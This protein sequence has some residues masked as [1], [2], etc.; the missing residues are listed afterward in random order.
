MSFGT[1]A[2]NLFL[3]ATENTVTD[4]FNRKLVPI[5][6]DNPMPVSAHTGDNLPPVLTDVSFD[7]NL[8]L[9]TL[10]FD[11][12]VNDTS[13]DVTRVRLVGAMASR[14]DLTGGIATATSLPVIQ[15]TLSNQ[16]L[17]N[18]KA[19]FNLAVSPTTISVQPRAN[20]VSDTS[21]NVIQEL[22]MTVPASVFIDDFNRPS[23][24]SFTLD[25]DADILI[26]TFN[27]TVDTNTLLVADLYLQHLRNSTVSISLSGSTVTSSP[28]S[29]VQISIGYS[30][31]TEIKRN[32]MLAV[33]RR[34]TW[35]SFDEIALNDTAANPV[36]PIDFM[37]AM[38]VDNF[39]DD[40]TAPLLTSYALDLNA[41]TL[42]LTFSET[43]DAFSVNF[44]TITLRSSPSDSAS[45]YTL[46]GGSVVPFMDDPVITIQFTFDDINAIKS[47]RSLATT[48]ATT[49]LSLGND[50]LF[51]MAGN[52]LN[53]VESQPITPSDYA[54]DATQPTL[55]SFDL[56]MRNGTEPLEIVLRFSESVDINSLFANL[57]TLHLTNQS[58]STTDYTLTGGTRSLPD[59]PNVTVFV[60]SADLTAIRARAPLAQF[61]ETSYLSVATGAVRDLASLSI[62]QQGLIPVSQYLADLI[63]PVV[64]DFSLDMN[65]GRL[66]LT[67]SEVIQFLTLDVTAIRLQATSSGPP[68]VTLSAS[69]QL[70]TTTNSSVM[71]IQISTSD[72]DQIKQFPNLAVG[73]NSTYIALSPTVRDIANN[74]VEE[75]FMTSAMR[76]SDYIPDST[77]P[78]LL[79]F[80][81]NVIDGTLTLTFDETVN[82]SSITPQNIQFAD[83]DDILTYTLTGGVSS[84]LYNSVVVFTLTE[85][86][87]NGLKAVDGVA[88]SLNNTYLNLFAG[89]ILDMNG[90]ANSPSLNRRASGFTK[91]T[92]DPVLETFDIDMDEGLL[93]LSFDETVNVSSLQ[94][95][96]IRLHGRSTVTYNLNTSSVNH[97]PLPTVTVQL[98][99]LDLN[100]LKRLRICLENDTCLLSFPST[101]VSDMVGRSVVAIATSTPQSVTNHTRDTTNPQLVDFTEI[102]LITREITLQFSETIDVT[103]FNSTQVTLQSFFVDDPPSVSYQ[104]NEVET[105]L[106]GDD[107]TLQFV[108]TQSDLFAIKDTED[109]C[110]RRSN[111]YVTITSATVQDM[112]GNMNDPILQEFPGKVV[113]T[114]RDDTVNPTLLRFDFDVNSGS[115]TLTFSE[116]MEAQSIDASGIT[117]LSMPF[118]PIFDQFTLTGGRTLNTSGDVVVVLQLSATDLN[119]LKASTFVKSDANTYLAISA[120]TITDVSFSRNRVSAMNISNPLRVSMYTRD[121]TPPE[122]LS[123]QLDLNSDQLI[124]TFNEPVSTNS[125]NFTALTLQNDSSTPIFSRT[126]VG[127][128]VLTTELASLV[129][130]TQLHPADISVLKLTDGFG[131]NTNNTYISAAQ[132]AFTDTANNPIEAITSMM[133][134]FHVSDT[135]RAR[136]MSFS[137]DMQTGQLDLTFSDIIVASMLDASAIGIQD[138]RFAND[139]SSVRLST[140]STT[141]SSDGYDITVSIHPLDLLRVKSVSGL[142]T[143]INTTWITMQ[144]FAI[145]DA[146]GQDVLAITNGKALRVTGFTADTTNPSVDGF[147]LDLNTG[148]LNITFSDTVDHLLL[149]V[150]LISIVSDRVPTI[151]L[152]LAGGQVDRSVNGRTVSVTLVVS[153]LNELK[154]NTAIGSTTSNTFLTIGPNVISDLAGNYLA[155]IPISAALQA[156]EIIPD[157]TGPELRSFELDLNAGRLIVTFSEPVDASSVNTLGYTLQS[158]RD[159]TFFRSEQYT[160]QTGVS[161]GVNGLVI[162][163]AFSEN[164]LNGIFAI[165]ALGNTVLDTYLIISNISVQDIG[166]N[167][168]IP[169][170]LTDGIQASSVSADTNA[171]RLISYVVDMNTGLLSLSFTEVVLTGSVRF[172]QI[173]LQNSP[174]ASESSTYT[175]TLTGGTT[176]SVEAETLNITFSEADLSV[177]QANLALATESSNTYLSFTSLTLTDAQNFPVIPV[178]RET[179]R[180]VTTFI[181]DTTP[182][183][184]LSFDFDLNS[185]NLSLTFDE[186][187]NTSRVTF[188]RIILRSSSNANATL[189]PL[190]GSTGDNGLASTV[191]INIGAGNLNNIKAN[192]TLATSAQTTHLSLQS[193]V[194]ED[195]NGNSY[196]DAATVRGVTRFTSD[197]TD[198]QLVNFDLNIDSGELILTFSETVNVEG[199]LDVR[200][201]TVQSEE[202]TADISVRLR[203]SISLSTNSP[204]I[205]I[206]LSPSDLNNLKSQPLLATNANNTYLSIL[207]LAIR[208]MANRPLQSI[209]STNAQP[210]QTFTEDRTGPEIDRFELDMNTGILALTFNEYVNESSLDLQY[211]TLRSSRDV[212]AETVTLTNSATIISFRGTAVMLQLSVQDVNAIKSQRSLATSID[213]TFLEAMANTIL[214]MN[215]NTLMSIPSNLAEP[216]E[217]YI[218]DT[219]RPSMISFEMDINTETLTIRFSETIDSLTADPTNITLQQDAQQLANFLTLSGGT[220]TSGDSPNITIR[221]SSVDLNELSRLGIC[222]A[223]D[224]CFIAFP[225]NTFDDMFGNPVIAIDESG[226]IS[227]R[228]FIVDRTPPMFVRFTSF[229]LDSGLLTLEFSETVRVSTVNFSALSFDA[230][231]HSSTPRYTLMHGGRVL[232][233]DREI[234]TI[235]LSTSDLNGIK[236]TQDVCDDEN[237]CW[238]RFTRDFIRDITDNQITEVASRADLG[239]ADLPGVFTPDTTRPLLTSFDL[240]LDNGELTLNFDE[241]IRF[242]DFS[243]TELTLANSSDALAFYQLTGGSRITSMDGTE[244]RFRLINSDLG[245]VKAAIDLATSQNNTYLNFTSD[246]VTDVSVMR[247]PVNTT[248]LS[249]GLLQVR[250]FV[251]DSTQPSLVSFVSLDMDD[252]LLTLQFSEAVEIATLDPQHL[253]LQSEPHATPAEMWSLTGGTPRYLDSLKTMVELSFNAEDLLRIKLLNILASSRMTSY[254]SVSVGAI[255]DTAGNNVVGITGSMA[256]QVG[257]YVADDSSPL[258]VNFTFDL[259]LGLLYLTFDDVMNNQMVDATQITFNGISDGSDSDNQY[260]LTGGT[261]S[262]NN[263][264][265]TV[266]MLIERD[267]NEIKKRTGLATNVN[268]T[269]I[270]MTAE[271]I[272]DVAGQ[273]VTPVVTANSRQTANYTSDTTQPM[274]RQFFFNVNAGTL[275]LSFSE[276]VNVSSLNSTGLTLQNQQDQA[277]ANRVFT[278]SGGTPSPDTNEVMF[279]VI[280]TQS[281]LNVIKT[282]TDFGTTVSNTFLAIT[283]GAVLDMN[284]NDLVEIVGTNA[285][286]AASH[287][288][289]STPPVL[290]NFTLDL[291]LGRLVL[292]MSE[293][294]NSLSVLPTGITLQA[295]QVISISNLEDYQTLVSGGNV[296]PA[297]GIYQTIELIREDLDAIKAKPFLAISLETT[298]ISLTS[299]TIT[300]FNGNNV[301]A[302]SPTNALQAINF[303]PDGTPPTLE[304]FDLLIGADQLVLTFSETVNGATLEPTLFTLLSSRNASNLISYSLTG[305][306]GVS[307]TNSSVV[308]IDILI[309]DL[310]AIK[311]DPNFGTAPENT[312]LIHNVSAVEDTS[313]NPIDILQIESARMATLVT[314]DSTSPRLESFTLNLSSDVLTLFFSETVNRASFDVTRI[315]IQNSSTITTSY[316]RLTRGRIPA[317]NNHIITIELDR[318]DS[319]EIKRLTTLATGPMNTYISFT[320]NLVPDLTNNFVEAISNSSARQVTLYTPDNTNPTLRSFDFLLA[321]GNTPPVLLILHFSETVQASTLNVQNIVLQ[322]NESTTDPT[323]MYALQF[324]TSS[325]SN[326]ADITINLGLEDYQAIQ[327]RPPLG[328]SDLNTYISVLGASVLDMANN[329]L[330]EIDV[331]NS[332][333]VFM[334]TADLTPPTL[335]E[336]SLD[337]DDGFLD[338]TWNEPVNE[339]VSFSGISLLSDPGNTTYFTLTSG[340]VIV[341]GERMLRLVLSPNDIN[342]IFADNALATSPSNTYIYLEQNVLMDIYLNPNDATPPTLADDYRDDRVRPTLIMFDL[343]LNAGMLTF[344]FSETVNASRLRPTEITFQNSQS[345]ATSSYTLTGGISLPS[346]SPIVVLNVSVTDQ[347]AIKALPNLAISNE[348]TYIAFGA[349][350]IVD[351]NDNR[352]NSISSSNAEVVRNFFPDVESPSLLF[353][354]FNLNTGTLT[355]SFDE[356]VNVTSLDISS[357]TLHSESSGPST[358]YTLTD[359]YSRQLYSS[360]VNI[361]LSNNDLNSIKNLRDLCSQDQAD[362]CYLTFPANTVVDMSGFP[363]FGV[364]REGVDLFTNDTTSPFLELFA[365]INLQT[366]QITLNFSE[367]IDFDT[368]SP[369]YISLQNLFEPPH[370]QLNLTGGSATQ[371]STTSVVINLT[372][373]DLASLKRAATICT[374][375][376]NCYIVA[377]PSLVRDIAGNDFAGIEQREPGVIVRNY[378]SDRLNPQLVNFDLD[379]DNSQLMLT[380]DEPVNTESL[381]I[382]GIT[383]QAQPT[384]SIAA[385]RYSLT[386]GSIYS[387]DATTI[388]VNLST[389][390]ANAI[391]ARTFATSNSDTYLTIDADTI[392]DLSSPP[393]GIEA[394]TTG[395]QVS[396]YTPDTTPSE[397]TG[398]SLDLQADELTL[399]FNEPMRTSTFNFTG[400]TI[401]SNCTGGG[402]FTL[403]GGVFVPRDLS[404]GAT[405]IT[406]SLLPADLITIKSDT[407]LATDA[408]NA[409]LQVDSDTVEDVAAQGLLPVDCLATAV[410]S[411]DT[412]RLQ[413]L[414]FDINMHLGILNLTFDDVVDSS[415]WNPEAVQFQSDIYSQP[416]LTYRLTSGSG[417][418]SL[419]GYLVTIQISNADL[420][421]IKSIFGLATRENDTYITMQASAIDDTLGVDV[422]AITDGKALRVR[423][424]IPDTVRPELIYY[425][426]DLDEG[427][428]NLTFN[429]FPNVSTLQFDQIELQNAMISASSILPLSPA[430]II[431]STDGFTITIVLNTTDLNAIK[432]QRN[433]A[434]SESTTFLS[435][436]R[437]SVVDFAGN[438]VIEISRTSARPVDNFTADTTGPE[439]IRYSFN[440]NNGVL[441]FTFTEVVDASTFNTS[442]IVLQDSRDVASASGV[443]RLTSGV[444]S[445]ADGTEITL[446]LSQQDIVGIQEQVTIGSSTGTTFISVEETLVMDTN[447]NPAMPI[448]ESDALQ[449][450]EQDFT[451][452]TTNPSLSQYTFDLDS[453]QLLL[454]FTKVIVV[455][456]IDY[457]RITLQSSSLAIGDMYTLTGGQALTNNSIMV[458]IELSSFDLNIVKATT[459]LAINVPTTF[460]SFPSTVFRDTRGLSIV[461]IFNFSALPVNTFIPDTTDPTLVFSELDMNTGFL[462]L[463]FSEAV[464]HDS[465]SI[466]SIRIAN[467]VTQEDTVSFRLTPDVVERYDNEATLRIRVQP[468]DLD[469]LK[470]EPLVATSMDDTFV[471][472]NSGAV[473]DFAGR[474]VPLTGPVM[475]TRYTADTT[476]PR[477]TSFNI[478]PAAGSITLTFDEAVNVSSFVVQNTEVTTRLNGSTYFLHDSTAGQLPTLRN[479]IDITLSPSEA[480]AL[481]NFAPDR[482]LLAITNITVFD[483]DGNSVQPI[484]SIMAGGW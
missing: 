419:N 75:I 108:L 360:E 227:V 370:D 463:N 215:Q 201:I 185:G 288:P 48:S 188:S 78:Q 345:G 166:G 162:T 248:L 65:N 245:R 74:L 392:F 364:S 381:N 52:A 72:L 95:E 125:V 243:F 385:E 465:L 198:P 93:I 164:D 134:T 36:I 112:S 397:L 426:L 217:G 319:N 405:L 218:S 344:V 34:T 16:D 301:L 124:F 447:S 343:D 399:T 236:L 225:N 411:P 226:A 313:G 159:A 282:F 386:E 122:L 79:G 464:R 297:A 440:V 138:G 209:F 259:N 457:T 352:V 375:R 476:G 146:F 137:I 472:L 171:P 170:P 183:L 337:L 451:P 97:A 262:S 155:E 231:F 430:E 415:T 83:M 73:M 6:I 118:A 355:L 342:A 46:T 341:L 446:M 279:D 224:N 354:N 59:S 453:G 207:S 14:Y 414:A 321:P 269:F 31:I 445:I 94:I 22:T 299:S 394:I 234:I 115:L 439:L 449:I 42:T 143:S 101:L 437:N 484:G 136:L 416:G 238:V 332:L 144:A 391:K 393:I 249:L 216:A 323:E 388:M 119:T 284:G 280:L 281:D 413:L 303:I 53:S 429:D 114:F 256:L 244:F 148:Q 384:S 458:D 26:L 191:T 54:T 268:D 38:R 320:N 154:N 408:G 120:N 68:S 99:T 351:M 325:Q 140:L 160:I 387:I 379:L 293:S 307:S 340:N 272:S 309:D 432:L 100:E 324:S 407:L 24:E 205:T 71:T 459:N 90:N 222:T 478:D 470:A 230:F 126:L 336:F 443:Y 232:G 161:T 420:L 110:D 37:N 190:T 322:Q 45:E 335:E 263:G 255:Q 310:N 85:T 433:L 199:S 70:L 135:T 116:P 91:D 211:L 347:N 377:T 460:L 373:S 302:I 378:I 412:V 157:T 418:S 130:T 103:T 181:P 330:D 467:N 98:S 214:D 29:T 456:Q 10:T 421:G 417:T 290:L 133:A 278:L 67:F 17:D 312:F 261:T 314:M 294:V 128:T 220:V 192:T 129:I 1:R 402:N 156:S 80:D 19:D 477:L 389:A 396:T 291:N 331:N 165:T 339:T 424:Y 47:I 176:G 425:A 362:D 329:P 66:T 308:T 283:R 158:K 41:D 195:T 163:L 62:D 448:L 187:V 206:M 107:T 184:L 406:I 444:P 374:Y 21:G 200:H 438:P 333:P 39:T 239:L 353:F 221:I 76:S 208:D 435:L 328:R 109:L 410:L 132:G 127:G 2:D 223:Q 212:T 311:R 63:P 327:A 305:S 182:P 8:G 49:F 105:I 30:A 409:F 210:V 88:T 168:A 265:E 481:S 202:N 318:T 371:L 179:A 350:L 257:Q 86:D 479:V 5:A 58:N 306:R 267:L 175:Y 150:S 104:L 82:S 7:L 196:S 474:A 117:F 167:P 482:N 266:L 326:S 473:R 431:V 356:T 434:V 349:D 264:Y 251:P 390:D 241:P 25:L 471:I 273:P 475:V 338:L 442:A 69:S 287:T 436:T 12:V 428:L 204:V 367:T 369:E 357:L 295:A 57:I 9:L 300:D 286:Q 106:T 4:G 233:S 395:I 43:V 213:S 316:H 363:V 113:T 246:L 361:T 219:N 197:S 23:L 147:L 55:L 96:E 372:M 346:V 270:S 455:D 77:S 348:T 89:A 274:L 398:F 203:D 271:F 194:I 193:G 258:L 60:S 32:R 380:F 51:D 178:D 376:G 235:E 180:Q 358:P 228:T 142:A 35:I 423:N 383:L 452:D 92:G 466:S 81:L 404:D 252:G 11:E 28:A 87:H 141:N 145:D 427:L 173:T 368:L 44:T 111:C 177:L 468:N 40:T 469:L 366:G 64:Q 403:T 20:L 121:S 400:I 149:N 289:D 365:E 359:S 131:T 242:V 298:Y 285:M 151:E 3:S 304:S 152:P 172:D 27:E 84:T 61:L 123:Y 275:T 174:N 15:I 317:G 454:T 186:V 56:V 334:H 401:K 139:V 441:V 169:V 102:N 247:N 292:T 18:I 461:P 276:T 382:P 50:T 422:L 33:S 260:Q 229:D 277:S 450:F 296:L 13:F 483:F 250:T 462:T 237:R 153:D 480:L 189:Y 315:I 240:N 253:T 254:I